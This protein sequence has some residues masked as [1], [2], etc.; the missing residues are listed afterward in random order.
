VGKNCDSLI[1]AMLEMF[2]G[3]PQEDYIVVKIGV[4]ICDNEQH[5]EAIDAELIN[6][7]DSDS[8]DCASGWSSFLGWGRKEAE[9]Q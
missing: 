8:L 6:R 5:A 1:E 2:G 7:I 3:N 4:M 9:E